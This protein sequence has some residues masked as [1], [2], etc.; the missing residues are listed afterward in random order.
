MKKI[1]VVL[2]MLFAFSNVQAV[3]CDTDTACEK[4]TTRS[5]IALE[6][7]IVKMEASI[8]KAKEKLQVKETKLKSFKDELV[9]LKDDTVQ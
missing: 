8:V 1:I 9:A 7:K 3:Q 6:K 5:V 2:M 4:K